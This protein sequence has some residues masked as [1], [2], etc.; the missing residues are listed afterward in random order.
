MWRPVSRHCEPPWEQSMTDCSWMRYQHSQLARIRTALQFTLDYNT[1][2]HHLKS[3]RKTQ[4]QRLLLWRLGLEVWLR[5]AAMKTTGV[6]RAWST[7]SN[8]G[9]SCSWHGMGSILSGQRGHCIPG[10][11][12]P[13]SGCQ[14]LCSLLVLPLLLKPDPQVLCGPLWTF[15]CKK[16]TSS[17]CL[18]VWPGRSLW[19]V[20][21]S[22]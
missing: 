10:D 1:G 15:L 13:S 20:P 18:G 4:I 22:R 14:Q 17:H 6:I 8:S 3:G 7:P 2:F 12:L 11:G 5:R 16:P 9:T 21:R 19:S